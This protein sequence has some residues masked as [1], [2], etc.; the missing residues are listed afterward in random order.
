MI[1]W[2]H[3]KIANLLKMKTIITLL[4]MRKLKPKRQNFSG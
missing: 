2:N 4:K 3:D 1:M